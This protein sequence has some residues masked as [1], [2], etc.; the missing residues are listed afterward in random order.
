MTNGIWSKHIGWIAVGAGVI[1]ATLYLL[2]IGVT[3][4]HL[5]AV[6][7]QIPFDMRPFGYGPGD[8]A[9]LLDA[10]GP[11]GRDY[12]LGRQIP[13]DTL[14][15]AMLALTLIATM[16]WFGRQRPN[17]QLVRF[18]ILSSVGAALF[19]YGENLGIIAMIWAWSDLPAPL[20]YVA[21]AA[22]IAKSILTTVAV[23]LTLLIMLLRFR[24]S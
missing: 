14:Y 1:A 10:L 3:L 21:S 5:Q 4:A 20:V 9:A 23:L 2:M 8:A 16:C 24:S 12:Y 7:G 18:G 22:S 11:E 6:S 13:L 17:S 19:D 15:P